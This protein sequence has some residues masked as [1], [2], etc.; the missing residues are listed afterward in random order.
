MDKAYWNKI[1]SGYNEEIFDAYKED[2]TGKLKRALKKYANQDH[3]AIDFGC[4]TGKA[5]PYLSPAFGNVLGID[6]SSALLRQ[7]K[8]LQFPNVTLKKLDLAKVVKLPDADFAFCCNVAILPDVE[9][10]K[11][12]IK[13]VQRALKKSGAAIFIIPSTES[14]LFSGWRIVDLYQREGI[15]FGKIPKGELDYFNVNKKQLLQGLF[16]ISGVPT[17]H[18]L[19]SEIQVLFAGAG[20]SIKKIDKLEYNWSTELAA[21]PKWLKEPYPWDWMIEC[22]KLK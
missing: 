11:G 10:N 6:I 15:D 3:V 21:P 2:R 9:K 17:K 16:R 1:G 13:N 4:G 5:L 20:L 12:I 19:H 7:A 18:Y 8:A 22:E 14:T